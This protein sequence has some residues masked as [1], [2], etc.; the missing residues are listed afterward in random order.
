MHLLLFAA[1]LLHPQEDLKQLQAVFNTS[2]GTFVME[3]YSDQAPNH[4]RKFIELARQGFYNGTTFHSMVAHGIVQ[5]GD[6]ET[7]NPQARTKYGSGGFNL[8]LKPEISNIPFAQGTIAATL[9]PG[10]PNSAGSEFMIVVTDQPQLTGQFTAFG[11]VVEGIEIVDKISTA[12][13]D[14][15]QIAKDR[16]EIRDITIRPRPVPAPPPFTQESTEE[17]LQYRVVMETSKGNILLDL[18]PDKAPNHVRH[19]LRLASVGAYDKTAFHRIAPGFVIQA[20]DLNTRLEPV[21]QAAQKY[22]VKIRAE[23]NDVKH[24]AGIVSMAR[25]EEID[26]ALTSFFIVLGDQPALDGTYTVFGRVAEGMDVV[27]KIA[28]TPTENERPK[29]RVDIYSIKVERKK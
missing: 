20:G 29:D 4:T 3:F 1:L 14:D 16:I 21:P 26:S 22:V 24:K 2:A 17:L 25:G 10:E 8:G 28:A 9:L 18:L 6:P 19:F 11:R 12:P 27:E 5:G 23:I 7:K 15:K 13:V